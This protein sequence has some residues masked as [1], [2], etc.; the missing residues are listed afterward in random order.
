AR[1]WPRRL[2]AACIVGLAGLAISVWLK[3]PG[4]RDI[5]QSTAVA[6]LTNAVGCTWETAQPPQLGKGLP[7]GR[8]ELTAGIAEITSTNGAVAVLGGAAVLDPLS[9]PRGFLR[10]GRIVVRVPPRA[11]SGFAIET[12][13]AKLV[14]RGTE[15]GVGVDTAGQTVVQ[16]FDGIVEADLKSGG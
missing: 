8:L 4:A 13:R 3:P 15:Y 6:T 1:R 16:V 10:A 7:A 14:D 9:P 12:Q 2:V 11:T 5:Q